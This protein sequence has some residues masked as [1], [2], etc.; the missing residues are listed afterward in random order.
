MRW[1]NCEKEREPNQ[2][3][4]RLFGWSNRNAES[5][6]GGNI[7]VSLITSRRGDSSGNTRHACSW[8]YLAPNPKSASTVSLPWLGRVGQ[9][10]VYPYLRAAH[11]VLRK[12]MIVG[13][14]EHIALQG[15][16]HMLLHALGQ[17]CHLVQDRNG[18][19]K[20]Y[21]LPGTSETETSCK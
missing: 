15:V 11:L 4:P 3:G 18:D 16:P 10:H 13:T 12:L 8:N 20:Y 14:A 17:G 7:A 6:Q 21:G 19:S 1:A 2:W 5:V 9:F